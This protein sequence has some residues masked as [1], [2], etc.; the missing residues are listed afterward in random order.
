MRQG[1]NKRSRNG[2]MNGR[3]PNQNIRGSLIESGGGEIRVKGT[4]AQLFE[5][6]QAL[7]RDA[8]A[9]GDRISA[10]NYL[11]HAEH[12]FRLMSDTVEKAPP[13]EAPPVLDA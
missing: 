8:A 5:R 1:A 2:R 12:Y 6:Y 10:E 3:R 4:P 13:V 9:L 11:Q 7:A